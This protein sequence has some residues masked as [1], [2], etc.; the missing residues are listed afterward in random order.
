VH[1]RGVKVYRSNLSFEA[2]EQD[3]RDREV[4][5]L[6]YIVLR[7]L[8]AAS[9]AVWINISVWFVGHA[10]D[11]VRAGPDIAWNIYPSQSICPFETQSICPFEIGLDR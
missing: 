2:E 9:F 4:A 10:W 7:M 8:G 3:Q 5:R 11:V 1:S 6:N